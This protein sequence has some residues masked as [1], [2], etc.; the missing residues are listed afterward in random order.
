MMGEVVY[1]SVDAQA[2]CQPAQTGATTQLPPA[3]TPAPLGYAD[4]FGAATLDSGWTWIRENASAW[5]L[6]GR[7]GWLFMDTAQGRLLFE[8][9][10]APLLLRAAPEGD[11]QATVLLDMHPTQDFQSAGIILYQDDDHFV[12]VSRAFCDTS[13]CV[14]D[15]VYM[16][17]DQ[18]AMAGGFPNNSVG[19]LPAQG[20]VYLKLVRTGTLI[21][22]YWSEDG[23]D[24]IRVAETEADL[25]Q[26]RIGLFADNSH[27]G[28]ATV[29]AYF[30]DF[31]VG[32][33][34][35]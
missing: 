12:D 5:N 28:R 23:S 32:P 33:V 35:P 15:G 31:S 18:R 2:L 11:L 13:L 16:D 6:T 17:D 3:A 30:D 19:G 10:D 21:T 34:E 9:G 7:A 27:P 25:P 4:G 14:G 24:W 22:G 8:G 26:A 29:P 1:C 20:P